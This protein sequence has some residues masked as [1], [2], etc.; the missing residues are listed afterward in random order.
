MHLRVLQSSLLLLSSKSCD[1]TEELLSQA[2]LMCFSLS[3]AR[4]ATVRNAAT[5]T[6]R[7]IIS[8]L[9]DKVQ[10]VAQTAKVRAEETAEALHDFLA[11][12]HKGGEE[13]AAAGEGG[14]RG[15]GATTPG[16][17]AC[18]AAGI[19]PTSPATIDGEP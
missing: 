11:A 16:E 5:A 1:M 10:N 7:Q 6:V 8:M 14:G 2:L 12:H 15:S 9:F 18:A 17:E 19:P 4:D 13:A 3:Q